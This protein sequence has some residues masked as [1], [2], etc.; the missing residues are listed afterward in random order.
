MLG[1]GAVNAE[2][3][4]SNSPREAQDSIQDDP[5]DICL[6]ECYIQSERESS[7]SG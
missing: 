7:D 3:R 5:D 1:K 2:I 6:L 4:E